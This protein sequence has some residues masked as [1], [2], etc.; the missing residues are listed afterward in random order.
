MAKYGSDQVVIK[1]STTSSTSAFQDISNQ[2]DTIS[3]LDMEALLQN[4]HAF[5]DAWEES[6][7]TGVKKFG[8]VVLE[9]FYDDVAASGVHTIFGNTSDL[10]AERVIKVYQAGTN[11]AANNSLKFD[12]IV[13]KYSRMPKRGELTR[14][15]I[16]LQP[17]GAVTTST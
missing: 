14:V 9:A 5:G 4:T 15:N 6:L 7:P 16:T 12:T 11:S 1:C 17:T 10:G 3:G 13:Q 8:P 2:V